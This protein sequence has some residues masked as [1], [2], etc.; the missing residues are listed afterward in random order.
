MTQLA[1]A[2]RDPLPSDEAEWRRLWHHYLASSGSLV[3]AE[4]TAAAWRRILDPTS[5]LAMRVAARG[6]DL[7]GFAIHLSHP[8]AWTMTGDC[9]LEDLYV[10]AT[11][12]GAGV[13]RA[14]LDD[15]IGLARGKGFARLYWLADM[16]NVGARR[17]YDS[18]V[19]SDG[20][21]RYRLDLARP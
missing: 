17:L 14:L 7:E 15:L 21:I 4:V 12:R 16:N 2:I 11:R 18:F 6:P 3:P 13:G 10:D 5:P 20:F 9:C 1:L 8:S 19:K